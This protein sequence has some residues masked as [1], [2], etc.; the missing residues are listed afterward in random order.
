MPRCELSGASLPA[1]LRVLLIAE[2]SR[3]GLHVLAHEPFARKDRLVFAPSSPAQVGMHWT[4]ASMLML[5]KYAIE[6]RRDCAAISEGGLTT[7]W[8]FLGWGA[9]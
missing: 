9:W 7:W 5:Q 8:G 1:S 4:C 2:L 3:D 6:S